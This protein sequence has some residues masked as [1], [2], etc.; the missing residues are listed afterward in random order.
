MNRLLLLAA[1]L[2]GCATPAVSKL[3]PPS[4]LGLTKGMSG[5]QARDIVLHA[6]PAFR[7][8]SIQAEDDDV[9]TV[10]TRAASPSVVIVREHL[11]V[12]TDVN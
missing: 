12:V 7:P 2:T 9:Q 8:L 3:A 10:Y 6:T 4:G 1:L 11:G 5:D